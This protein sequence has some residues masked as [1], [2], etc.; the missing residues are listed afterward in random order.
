MISRMISAGILILFATLT[1]FAAEHAPQSKFNP[2]KDEAARKYPQI[3][4]YSTS[5]CP[6]CKAA[7]EYLTKNSIP[8]INRDVEL[9]SQ[10]AELLTDKYKSQG[11]P[12]IVLGS[13]TDEVVMKG[14]NPE[15]FQQSL[16]KVRGK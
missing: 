7:K 5:W 15:L 2:I 9:D 13:G 12:L 14:F 8:F 11:V 1:C 6:H 4:L 16:K 10:A 3:V